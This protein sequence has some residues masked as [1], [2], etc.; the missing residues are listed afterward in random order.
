MYYNLH[1][2]IVIHKLGDVSCTTNVLEVLLTNIVNNVL[3]R[4]LGTDCIV[5]DVYDMLGSLPQNIFI[6][7]CVQLVCIYR[8]QF[9]VMQD[10]V[11][12]MPESSFAMSLWL[13]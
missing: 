13:L 5:Y 2:S 10:K 1:Y 9:S 4:T 12:L 8:L 3:S 7:L 11:A 6:C